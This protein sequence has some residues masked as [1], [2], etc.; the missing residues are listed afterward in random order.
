IP[1]P[2]DG[3]RIVLGRHFHRRRRFV[4]HL[5]QPPCLPANCQTKTAFRPQ[6][7]KAV[8]SFRGT[9]LLPARTLPQPPGATAACSARRGLAR[10]HAALPHELSDG[11]NGP[12]PAAPTDRPAKPALRPSR[13]ATATPAA[14]S[15]AAPGRPSDVS[16]GGP[17]SQGSTSLQGEAASYSSPSSPLP[18][19]HGRAYQRIALWENGHTAQRRLTSPAPACHTRA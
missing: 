4:R 14:F 7:R 15:A 12:N 9:T 18:A 3:V 11:A 16:P 8:A 19:R 6:G 13:P 17:R 10:V 2:L 5:V 1:L